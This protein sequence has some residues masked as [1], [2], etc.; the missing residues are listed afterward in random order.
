M[1]EHAALRI[2]RRP[3]RVNQAA[4]LA[5]FLLLHLGYNHFISDCRFTNLHEVLPKEKAIALA[6]F[7]QHCFP[8]DNEGLDPRISIQIACET[9]QVLG[10]LAYDHFSF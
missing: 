6:S 8:P 7:R 5:R 4:T 9:L 10:C 3:T 2:S 1:A